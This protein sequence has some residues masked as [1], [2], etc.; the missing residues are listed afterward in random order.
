MEKN[1][2]YA[3]VGLST[4][5]LVAALAIFIVWLARFQFAQANDTYDILFQGPVRGLSEGGEVQF[6]G[7]KVGEVTKIALDRTNPSRVI[8][9]VQVTSDV[10]IRV[11]SYATLEPQGITGVNYIQI[12]AGTPSRPLLKD[13]AQKRCEREGIGIG[14]ECIPVLRSQ[15]STLSDLLEGGG[16]VLTRTIE[17]LDRVNRVLSD[18]NIKTFSAALSDTQAVTAELRERKAIIADAQQA[19]QRVEEATAEITLLTRSTRDLIETDGR[20]TTRNLADAAEEA[21]AAAADV[22][23]MVGRLQ[24]PTTDFATNGLPQI[25]ASVSQLQE[26]A[27]S[28]ER[29][30]N[31][32]QSRGIAGSVSKRSEEVKVPQ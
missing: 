2:N 25:T 15:R 1:A 28:L 10:P 24:G 17:A 5:I 30:L 23:T 3:L 4:L 16:T 7:I 18:E 11:D 6:N 32:L 29:L 22:R 14:R 31:E 21:R 26:T 9:R 19:L 20:R 8:A 27:E 13:E 12:T